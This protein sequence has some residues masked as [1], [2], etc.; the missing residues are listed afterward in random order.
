MLPQRCY[1]IISTTLST[2]VGETFISS[3]MTTSLQPI[4]SRCYNVVT[5]SLRLLDK[6]I[7]SLEKPIK[8]L[9]KW[10][11]DNLIKSNADKCRLLVS[12][13][14]TANTKMR[15]ISITN[16]ACETFRSRN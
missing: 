9:F 10:F 7:L 2:D 3:D 11:S 5:A 16:S 14:T 8:G 15:N 1:S 6:F 13:N 12:A 4:V